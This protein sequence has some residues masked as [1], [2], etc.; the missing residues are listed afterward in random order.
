M[1]KR[2]KFLTANSHIYTKL[3]S[4]RYSVCLWAYTSMCGPYNDR[5]SPVNFLL[6]VLDGGIYLTL[7]ID[8]ANSM[9]SNPLARGSLPPT[10]PPGSRTLA[11]AILT[12]NKSP[13]SLLQSSELGLW[14]QKGEENHRCDSIFDNVTKIGEKVRREKGTK[15]RQETRDKRQGRGA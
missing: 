1:K 3:F 11:P 13:T 14:G 9:Q 6:V 10:F 15:K 12:R 4:R 2:V 7:S 8:A 5:V